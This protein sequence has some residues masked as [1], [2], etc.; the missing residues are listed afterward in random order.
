MSRGQAQ[1]KKICTQQRDTIS[2]TCRGPLSPS[3]SCLLVPRTRRG[4]VKV[5]GIAA[6]ML[7]GVR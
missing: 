3:L 5:R 1:E 7:M 4:S 2:N 6:V